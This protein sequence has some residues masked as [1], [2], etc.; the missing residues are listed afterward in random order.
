MDVDIEQKFEAVQCLARASLMMREPGNW[1][2]SQSVEV[3]NGS[4][5]EG[6]YGNGKT[7]EEAIQDHWEQL[8]ELDPGEYIVINAASDN[9]KAVRWNGYM[10][11]E[12]DEN[13]KTS[14]SHNGTE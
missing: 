14:T 5:L 10:W 8:T 11:S 13:L 4:M 3:K 9:R 2:V 12:V 6:R 7:P 1:Y